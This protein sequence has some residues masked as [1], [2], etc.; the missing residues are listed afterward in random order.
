[1]QAGGK[2]TVGIIGGMGPEAANR[3]SSLLV[4]LHDA[5]SDQEQIPVI[6]FN[7]P[8]IPSRAE[9]Y[10]GTGP[11]PTKELIATAEAL[12]RA[13]AN[14]LIM[15]CNSAH[16]YLGEL[17]AQVQIPVLDMIYETVEEIGLLYPEARSAG[18]LATTQTVQQ[19]LYDNLLAR[20]NIAILAP[21][22]IEQSSVMESIYGEAGIKAGYK[23]KAKVEIE[24]VGQSLVTR[25][26]D[27]LIA[28]CTEVSI[29]LE[30]QIG[31][32]PIID[33]LLVIARKAIKLSLSGI[34]IEAPPKATPWTPPV[35]RR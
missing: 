27:I 8:R 15:P 17:R 14:F 33:P 4:S 22:A 25:G 29:V 19:K 1:M 18:I 12:M 31:G 28:A 6:C 32:V 20:Q 21:D 35:V 16:H 10:S 9:A 13:G 7:N 5:T 24:K 23:E 3:L 34:S 30:E 2:L 11:L 26:A